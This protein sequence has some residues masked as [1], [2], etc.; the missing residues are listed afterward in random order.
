METVLGQCHCGGVQF[1]VDLEQGLQSLRRCNCS[2]CRRKGA[3]MA[4]VPVTHL[5]V[6]LGAE[7]L[8]LYQWNQKIAKHYFCRTCG[9]YTH[10]Q[11]RSQPDH[12]GFNVGCLEGDAFKSITDAPIADGASMSVAE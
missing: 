12:Y 11:Q 1:E 7:N 2:L 4:S 5:R 3:M 6:I 8:S 9:I 10:H